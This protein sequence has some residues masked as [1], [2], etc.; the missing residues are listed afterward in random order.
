VNDLQLRLPVHEVPGA[1]GTPASV[2]NPLPPVSANPQPACVAHPYSRIAR[3]RSHASRKGFVVV[4]TAGEFHCARASGI[5]R[6]H[7]KLAKVY[8]MIYRN[9][10]HGRCRFLERGGK[11]SRPRPCK[12]PIEF[13]ARG[14]LHWSLRLRIPVPR[15][16]Y[17]IRADAVDQ[18]RHHQC[19]TAASTIWVRVA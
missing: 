11:L 19:R 1:P 9:A 10:G 14:T 13:R 8:V 2:T 4:G 12:R 6:R 5:N 3:R 18:L 15:G 7:Q 16:R 17:L